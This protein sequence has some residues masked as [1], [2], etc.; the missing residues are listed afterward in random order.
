M[1]ETEMTRQDPDKRT[2][3]DLLQDLQVKYSLLTVMEE[4]ALLNLPDAEKN[5]GFRNLEHRTVLVDPA[6]F[7][8][9]EDVLSAISQLTSEKNP[10]R[11]HLKKVVSQDKVFLKGLEKAYGVELSEQESHKILKMAVNESAV[12]SYWSAMEIVAYHS[13]KSRKIAEIDGSFVPIKTKKQFEY[14]FHTHVDESRITTVDDDFEH[15]GAAYQTVTAT[16]THSA[17]LVFDGADF[18]T[19]SQFFD[20]VTTRICGN[21]ERQKKRGESAPL[22]VWHKRFKDELTVFFKAKIG[23]NGYAKDYLDS[24]VRG[25]QREK[26]RVKGLDEAALVRDAFMDAIETGDFSNRE[27][28]CMIAS[29]RGH[30]ARAISRFTGFSVKE[31][32]ET[33]ESAIPK[34]SE[35]IY[36]MFCLKYQQSETEEGRKATENLVRQILVKPD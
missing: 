9:N 6:S 22:M 17:S 7:T 18:E 15:P 32:E 31:I 36:R 24:K 13:F 10:D 27:Y 4:K 3:F 16:D 5:N 1:V 8:L 26:K 28:T 14:Y 35:I 29:N 30:A 25:L 19:F 21:L 2:P 23:G 11:K 33:I 34:A 20:Y 12:T